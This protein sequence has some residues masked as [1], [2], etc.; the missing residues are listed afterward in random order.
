METL[1]Y[2]ILSINEKHSRYKNPCQT[3]FHQGQDH[4]QGRQPWLERLIERLPPLCGQSEKGNIETTLKSR[5]TYIFV[6]NG[7]D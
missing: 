5:P 2:T 3:W 4:S 7:T 1:Y 6:Y